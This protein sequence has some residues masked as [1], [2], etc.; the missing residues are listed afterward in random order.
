MKQVVQTVADEH[1]E[2]PGGNTKEEPA[3]DPVDTAADEVELTH[4]LLESRE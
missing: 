1:P 2:Q 3:A 4:K